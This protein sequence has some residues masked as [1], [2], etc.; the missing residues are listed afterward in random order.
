LQAENS[1]IAM[2][3]SVASFAATRKQKRESRPE[4]RLSMKLNDQPLKISGYEP[5]ELPGCSIPRQ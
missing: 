5:D 4:G 2:P 1:D 3:P